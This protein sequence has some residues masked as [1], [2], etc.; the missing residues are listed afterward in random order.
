MPSFQFTRHVSSLPLVSD[1]E[2]D[3]F[4][5]FFQQAGLANPFQA[6]MIQT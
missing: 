4:S 2:V 1:D 3:M 5:D 6:T